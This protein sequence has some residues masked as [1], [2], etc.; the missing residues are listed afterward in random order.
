MPK[1]ATA[2]PIP[3]NNSFKIGSELLLQETG[4]QDTNLLFL[5]EQKSNP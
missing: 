4:L 1:L 3:S 5:R 2:P